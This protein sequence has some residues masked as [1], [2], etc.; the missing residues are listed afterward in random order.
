MTIWEIRLN[1]LSLCLPAASCVIHIHPKAGL[2]DYNACKPTHQFPDYEIRHVG[3]RARAAVSVSG[4]CAQ[5]GY[6]EVRLTYNEIAE[7]LSVKM[8]LRGQFV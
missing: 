8:I 6:L 5:S 1:E 3:K 2:I 4:S 7:S